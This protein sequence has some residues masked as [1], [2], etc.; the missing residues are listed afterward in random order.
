MQSNKRGIFYFFMLK[1]AREEL[2]QVAVMPSNQCVSRITILGA[3][4]IFSSDMESYMV[5]DLL[6]LFSVSIS[7][8]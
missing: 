2:L 4:S 5:Q 3:L 6:G 7:C 8:R 1:A